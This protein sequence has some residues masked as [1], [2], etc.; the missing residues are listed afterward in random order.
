MK[1]K[2]KAGK[3][4]ADYK[5]NKA[6]SATHSGKRSWTSDQMRSALDMIR[7]KKLSTKAASEKFN[8]PFST[9]AVYVRENKPIPNDDDQRESVDENHMLDEFD[10]TDS[11]FG[12]NSN[13]DNNSIKSMSTF[14]SCSLNGA[15]NKNSSKF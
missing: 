3:K 15:S 10:D 13:D 12:E 4:D 9:L 5:P 8:I 14:N 2:D 11:N 7:R 6:K 1:I